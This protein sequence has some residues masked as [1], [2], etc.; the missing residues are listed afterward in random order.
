MINMAEQSKILENGDIEESKIFYREVK[1]KRETSKVD[2]KT[3]SSHSALSDI[4][5]LL[6]YIKKEKLKYPINLSESNMDNLHRK[7][8]K[9]VIRR[10]DLFEVRVE[11]L[12]SQ[13]CDKLKKRQKEKGKYAMIVIFGESFLLAHI[14]TEEGISI[15][16]EEG[17]I[18]LIKRF[19]DTDNIL[20]AALFEKKED[21]IKFSHFTDTGSSSFRNFIGVSKRK[22]YSRRKNVQIICFY[23]G[24]LGLRFKMEFTNEELEEKWL[25]ENKINLSD[26]YLHIN[27]TSHQIKEII[28]GNKTYGS[29]NQF[30][31]EF[32]E[33]I[34]GLENQKKK[35]QDLK[36]LSEK[37]SKYFNTIKDYEDRIEI[38]NDEI[39]VEEKGDLPDELYVVYADSNID[40]DTSFSDKIFSRVMNG[41]PCS[42]YHPSSPVGSNELGIRDLNIL[43]FNESDL[44]DEYKRFLTNLYDHIQNCTG[45]S[46][47]R[48]LTLILFH[49]IAR[50]ANQ[51]FQE[52][53]IQIINL[54]T[55]SPRY[56]DVVTTKEMEVGG[57]I[58][59]KDKDDLKK[60]RAV[61]SIIENI[62]K[63]LDIHKNKLFLWGINEETRRIEGLRKQMWGDDRVTILEKKT[64]EKLKQKET[65]IHDFKMIN[66][67]LD[68]GD[69][70]ILIGIVY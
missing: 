25:R 28:W 67:P 51:Q 61:E 52:A 8:V 53:I 24:K 9:E 43:N 54:N 22:F 14:K 17:D 58:E 16:E 35:Y 11:D 69:Y 42:I 32:K 41:L 48:C 57:L 3:I 64:L 23:E 62:E 26:S 46:V 40:L 31:S 36:S 70:C 56:K 13:F 6:D 66:I 30:K 39:E 49:L 60:D 12:L 21:Q 63:A 19:L 68:E 5:N 37:R 7:S 65:S 2:E 59:Y 33:Y 44:T 20:S 4:N 50:E 34:Y 1:T 45:E 55:G 29:V 27:E 15:S 38:V 10:G 47:K 18:A